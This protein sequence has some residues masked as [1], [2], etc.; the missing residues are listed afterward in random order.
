MRLN[1]VLG[2]LVEVAV[3]ETKKSARANNAQ[4]GVLAL[5][6]TMLRTLTLHLS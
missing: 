3:V 4:D 6:P 2:R 1:T 5:D